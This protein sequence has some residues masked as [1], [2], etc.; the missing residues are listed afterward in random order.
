MYFSTSCNLLLYGMDISISEHI[1]T[2]NQKHRLIIGCH[3]DVSHVMELTQNF[4]RFCS[5]RSSPR[6][7]V[8]EWWVWATVCWKQPYHRPDMWWTLP[9]P[10]ICERWDGI[11][12][13]DGDKV[14]SREECCNWLKAEASVPMH[15]RFTPSDVSMNTYCSCFHLRKAFQKIHN[16]DNEGLHLQSVCFKFRCPSISFQCKEPLFRIR[17]QKANFKIPTPWVGHL[18]Y[19]DLSSSINWTRIT[20]TVGPDYQPKNTQYLYPPWN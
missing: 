13:W 4:Q 12:P 14:T 3:S 9:G 1:R 16:D 18:P 15:K 10:T 19:Q 7:W 11:W 2:T 20:I 5:T 6:P 8:H 17:N